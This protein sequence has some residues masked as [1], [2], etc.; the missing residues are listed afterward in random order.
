MYFTIS[1]VIKI[2]IKIP[3]EDVIASGNTFVNNF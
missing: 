2:K 1:Y 3:I